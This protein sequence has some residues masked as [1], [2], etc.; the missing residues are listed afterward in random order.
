MPYDVT[1]AQINAN[2]FGLS[3]ANSAW[4]FP[5]N[6]DFHTLLLSYWMCGPFGT[7]P[8]TL[9]LYSSIWP[10]FLSAPFF[11]FDAGAANNITFTN[12]M[13]GS[14][15]HFYQGV[16]AFPSPGY[17]VHM[18]MSADLHAQVVQVYVNDAP[19][20]LT[21]ETWTGTPPF[22]FNIANTIN[23]WEWNVAGTIASGSHPALG[24]AWLHNTPA[25]VDLSVVANRRRF[26]NADLTPVNLGDTG[27]E[28]F[29]YQP[30]MYMSIRPGGVAADILLNRGLGGGSWNASAPP[31]T[32][33]APG[34]CILPMPPPPTLAMDN[35]TAFAEEIT[36]QGQLVFLSWSD[37]RGHSWS[38]PVG[39]PIG[40]RGDYLASI[41]WQRLGL[42]R[43]RVFRLT[44]SVPVA[45]A[46]L[47]AYIEADT[48]AKS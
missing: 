46:I 17:R 22:N 4:G 44:F 12:Q 2:I 42:A 5:A 39:Q 18:M 10:E 25:F 15:A 1:L 9:H 16:W 36:P 29:G 47:G 21:G 11:S 43:D 8:T 31:P 20:T 6:T 3:R 23:I 34:S 32:I 41:Q 19:V 14:A 28:P 37:D 45:T 30:A 40:A 13:L 27:T 48:S 24:D 33:Q 35:V 7:S 26:I 38:N